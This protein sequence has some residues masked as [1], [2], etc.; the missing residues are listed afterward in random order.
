MSPERRE[1]LAHRLTTA[2]AFHL[3]RIVPSWKVE[4]VD[5]HHLVPGKTF[6]V[7]AN[8]QSFSDVLVLCGLNH[9]FKW[10]AKSE[11]LGF[12]GV[13]HLIK[14]NR[15]ITVRHGSLAS[16]KNMLKQARAALQ[17]GVSVFIFPEGTRSLDGE[18]LSF[19]EGPFRLACETGVP[20]IPVVVE[21]TRRILPTG[22]WVLNFRANVKIKLLTPVDPA[23]FN[24]DS[25]AL[26]QYVRAM[27]ETELQQMRHNSQHSHS[28][29]HR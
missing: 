5:K 10:I 17:R 4:F 3:I 19:K 24:G 23:L 9:S 11:I 28:K 21:G 26:C 8:H 22:E 29:S 12:F 14:L 6:M 18:L 1:R 7:V 16:V 2:L 20:I 25:K 15:Y 27:I 13:G